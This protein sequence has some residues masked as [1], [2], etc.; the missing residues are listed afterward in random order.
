MIHLRSTRDGDAHPPGPCALCTAPATV[1]R[2]AT[3]RCGLVVAAYACDAH[4]GAVL[5]A[6]DA[7]T[8][9]EVATL[10]RPSRRARRAAQARR[11]AERF[12][13]FARGW[14]RESARLRGASSAT[15]TAALMGG[16]MEQRARAY[17][18]LAVALSE[19]A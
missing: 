3:A 12:F 16:A 15:H 14:S 13:R 7:V 4:E 2:R 11:M 5:A 19:R 1:W 18:A 6:L 9:Q 17:T 8:I 10:V